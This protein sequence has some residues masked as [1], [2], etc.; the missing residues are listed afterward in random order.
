MTSEKAALKNFLVWDAGVC[1]EEMITF[2]WPRLERKIPDQ[3]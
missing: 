1:V 3:T 2:W